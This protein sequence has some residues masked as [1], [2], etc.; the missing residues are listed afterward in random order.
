MT[1]NFDTNDGS[2]LSII[3]PA[4]LKKTA[5]F[6]TAA[7]CLVNTGAKPCT[8]VTNT[9]YTNI[10]IASQSSE[11]LFPKAASQNIEI[12]NLKFDRTSSHTYDGVYHLYFSMRVSQA[13]DAT[14]K[15]LLKKVVVLPERER[16][17]SLG[18]YFSNNLKSMS[19]NYPNIVR[20]VSK[21]TAQWGYTVQVYERRMI[22]IYAK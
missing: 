15:N 2:S 7:S 9:T 5:N 4:K 13:V 20:L 14:R 22:S 6:N 12:N 16:M 10:T 8:V 21:S 11:N 1:P 3:A 18:L 19:A 17:A